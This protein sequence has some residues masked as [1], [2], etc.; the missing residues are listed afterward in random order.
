[1]VEIEDGFGEAVQSIDSTILYSDDNNVCNRVVVSLK[2]S[3]L[4][5]TPIPIGLCKVD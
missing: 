5:P 2:M 1:M 4:M 3:V